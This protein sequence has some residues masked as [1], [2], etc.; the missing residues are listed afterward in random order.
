MNIPKLMDCFPYLFTINYLVWIRAR[1]LFLIA[2]LVKHEVSEASSL[3]S[4]P[5]HKWIVLAPSVQ[6]N[7]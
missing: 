4:I 1:K 2:Q 3:V 7:G 6:C 5:E